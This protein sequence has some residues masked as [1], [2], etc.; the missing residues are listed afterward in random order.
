MPV[1][2]HDHSCGLVRDPTRGPEI[3]VAGGEGYEGEGVIGSDGVND[4][5]F[6]NR[7]DIYNV[8]TDSWREGKIMQEI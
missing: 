4:I 2:R 6:Y 7:V 8:D 5:G 3:V 1:D